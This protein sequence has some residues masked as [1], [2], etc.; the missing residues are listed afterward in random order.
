M[1]PRAEDPLTV[2]EERLRAAFAA[3]AAL[4][5][6]RD[7]RRDEPPEGRSWGLRRVRGVAFA[8][9]GTVAAAA[10]VAA[11][12]LFFLVPAGTLSPTPAPPARPPGVSKSPVAPT[13]SPV[14]PSVTGPGAA[15]EPGAV[16]PSG[17]GPK[18]GAVPGP[19]AKPEPGAEPAAGAV[20]PQPGVDPTPPEG[21]RPVGRP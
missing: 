5:T 13:P 11:A 21:P 1:R 4:V 19:G 9:L 16:R 2:T 8:S 7:L 14:A 18:P 3:R 10:A 17:S 20:P 12:Y 6:Y 15:P